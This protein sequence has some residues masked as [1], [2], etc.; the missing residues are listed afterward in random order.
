MIWRPEIAARNVNAETAWTLALLMLLVAV[1]PHHAT[2]I[3]P[4]LN[5]IGEEFSVSDATVGQIGTITFGTAFVVALA[6]APFV[7]R[8]ELRKIP[9]LAEDTT[10]GNGS[11]PSFR[12]Y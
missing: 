7:G 8:Y 11:S 12:Y 4:F 10:G 1:A 6:I 9:L 5:E 2:S 3:S